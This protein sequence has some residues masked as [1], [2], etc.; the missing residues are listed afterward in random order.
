MASKVRLTAL[1][2]SFLGLERTGLPMHVAGVVALEPSPDRDPITMRELRRHVASRI[3]WLPRFQQRIA[4]DPFGL[5]PRWID[6]RPVDLDAHLFHHPLPARASDADFA[7][8]C[9]QVHADPLPHDRPLWQ[10]HLI[11]AGT[12]QALI[13]KTH[14]SIADGVGGIHIAETLF[15][16]VQPSRH[17]AVTTPAMNYGSGLASRAMRAG[18][19]VV[20]AAFTAAGG[21]IALLSPY[22]VV[23]GHDR[24]V[25][26]TALPMDSILAL[27]KKLGG[28]VDD[29][30]LALV[31]SGLRGLDRAR[32]AS[33]MPLRAM[34]PVSTWM[35]GRDAGTGNHVTAIFVDLPQDTGDLGA[36]VARIAGSK[37]VLRTAHAAAGMAMLVQATGLLP[38]PL[39]RAVVR[40]ATSLPFANLVVSDTPGPEQP[41]A[42]LGRRIAA[43]YPLIPLPRTVG[44]SIAAVSLGGVMGV[45]IAADPRALAHPE[46]LAAE[47]A[48]PLRKP[49]KRVARPSRRPAA[50]I[51][52]QAA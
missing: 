46:R 18:Q 7:R 29:V 24:V 30:L 39:H 15:D 13:V 28:S 26:F 40:T 19:A 10:M 41:L 38:A 44:L 34:L 45:G 49:A 27:K 17:R 3:R 2:A 36:L 8:V 43:C 42:L 47:I 23:V 48:R 52:A 22:N 12:R 20:G 14:H 50:R 6:A 16:P 5:W 33:R 4:V 51:P 35:P 32:G 31:A 9:A 25:A 11:D 1:E 21:P 37:A